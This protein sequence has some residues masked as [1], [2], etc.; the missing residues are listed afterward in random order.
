M[1]YFPAVIVTTGLPSPEMETLVVTQ[2]SSDLSL[3]EVFALVFQL[4]YASVPLQLQAI[5]LSPLS[6]C[7]H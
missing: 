4:Q 1:A 2:S 3:G 5:Q 7:Q 6:S